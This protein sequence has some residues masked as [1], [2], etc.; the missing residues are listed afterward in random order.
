MVRTD[1][2]YKLS[3]KLGAVFTSNEDCCGRNL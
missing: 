3:M 2:R 1:D